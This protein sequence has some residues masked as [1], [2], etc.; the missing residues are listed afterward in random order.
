MGPLAS[1]SSLSLFG[2]EGHA[3]NRMC[4]KT[5]QHT[6]QATAGIV[7]VCC[8]YLSWRTKSF[9]LGCHG[10]RVPHLRFGILILGLPVFFTQLGSVNHRAL[11]L[12]LPHQTILRT[13]S[14]ISLD[15]AGR[16]VAQQVKRLLC[17]HK[18]PGSDPQHPFITSAGEES[19]ESPW[20]AAAGQ[21][22]CISE[23]QA[24]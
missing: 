13:V 7:F 24:Q 10:F 17:K 16:E 3:P 8:L 12:S 11:G 21:P 9:P 22:C 18:G 19:Q 2:G 15:R 4:L 23:R 20:S 6:S 1:T 14:R 5:N